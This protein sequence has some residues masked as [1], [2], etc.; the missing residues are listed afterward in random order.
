M[1]TDVTLTRNV[2]GT[3]AARLV[4]GA[5]QPIA[6]QT[7][8]FAFD[9]DGDATGEVYTATTGA[10]GFAFAPVLPSRPIG[11]ALYSVA[12]DGVRVTAG[13]SATVHVALRLFLPVMM[14]QSGS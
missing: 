4:N 5:G 13:A 12:W 7:V 11:A 3:L 2:P 9:A 14:R 8:V 10:D 1:V 6:G